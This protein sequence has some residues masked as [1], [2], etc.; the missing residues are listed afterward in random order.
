M[1]SKRYREFSVE[2]CEEAVAKCFERK[3]DRNDIL[4]FIEKYAGIPRIEI[5]I[6]NLEGAWDLR[7]EA[8]H[9]IGLVLYG[10]IEDLT[11]Y[12]IEPTDYI[13]EVKT[14]KRPDGMT[15]K[16]REIALLSIMHQLLGHTEKL[17]IDPLIEARLL[18][19]QNASLPG[20]GQTKLKDQLHRDLLE[21]S[22]G[23][24]YMRKTDV[25]HAYKTTM[26]S[27]AVRRLKEEIPKAKTAIRLM[28]YLE[29]IAPGHHLIIGGYLDAWLFNFLMSYSIR[30][31]YKQGQTR[32]GKFTRD[33]ITVNTYMDDFVIGTKSIKAQ[34]RSLK[35]LDNSFEKEYGLEVKATTGVMKILPVE[36][37]KRRRGLTKSR[38]GTPAVDVAGYRIS[39]THVTIRRRVFKKVR[40]QLL[41]GWEE[42][43]STGTLRKQR[44]KALIAYNGYI[45]QTNSEHLK[46][47]YHVEALMT[48]AKKVDAYYG[49]QEQKK[50]KERLHDLQ[51]R[52]RKRETE[53]GIDREPSRR[54]EDDPTCGQRRGVQAAGRE[55]QCDGKDS[56]PF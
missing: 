54:E 27:S 16:I 6:E 20:R 31:V 50:R 51:E 26:Y 41:R 7:S 19:T 39:R 29:K 11:E 8:V 14:R 34:K 33:A 56:I 28:E 45:E 40:R 24:V 43:E 17:M 22:K 37:E 4:T 38:R 12:G 1:H 36:E 49:R 13:R 18:P 30:D 21:E 44:A 52:R 3:W 2:L 35:A 46:E 5:Q 10:I 42:L 55:G 48:V 32:R 23:I 47:K 15:G 25:V 9:S 53:E